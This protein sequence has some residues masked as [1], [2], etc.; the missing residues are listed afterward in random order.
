MTE[1]QQIR[2][3]ELLK[4]KSDLNNDLS[5]LFDKDVKFTICFTYGKSLLYNIELN[6]NKVANINSIL[7][8]KV[9][10]LIQKELNII[11]QE[12]NLI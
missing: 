8:D 2:V 3:S 7:K 4:Q 6:C 12:L 11:E 5:K 1:E 9:I 10:E